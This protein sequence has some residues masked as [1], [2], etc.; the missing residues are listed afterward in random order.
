MA[1]GPNAIQQWQ[2]KNCDLS[3]RQRPTYGNI[4]KI[5]ISISLVLSF[6]SHYDQDA[7]IRIIKCLKV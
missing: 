4:T 7:I 3:P 1:R 2:P 6:H 5:T